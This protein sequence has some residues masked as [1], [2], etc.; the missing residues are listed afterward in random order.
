[1]HLLNGS[2]INSQTRNY[3]NLSKQCRTKGSSKAR[4]CK[5]FIP[6]AHKVS[7]ETEFTST[8]LQES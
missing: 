5:K 6:H 2:A 8:G 7:A 3:L 4:L 1:M